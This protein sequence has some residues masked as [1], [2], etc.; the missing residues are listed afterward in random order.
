[1][2]I[3]L[4]L[5]LGAIIRSTVVLGYRK[6][7]LLCSGV[8]LHTILFGENWQTFRGK[9]RVK[10]WGGMH[11][12]LAGL[13]LLLYKAYEIST[14]LQNQKISETPDKLFWK[15]AHICSSFGTVFREKSCLFWCFVRRLYNAVN[16]KVDLC[17]WHNK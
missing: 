8:L 14:L 1:M 9:A 17:Y 10:G 16:N 2:Q 4:S 15:I 6:R 11:N 13:L 3:K 5:F 12:Y 7:R